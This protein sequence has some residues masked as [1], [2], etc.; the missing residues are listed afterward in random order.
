M[1]KK[2]SYFPVL[3]GVL[4]LLIFLSIVEYLVWLEYDR[5]I[6]T[7]KARNNTAVGLVRAKL[8]TEINRT[9]YLGLGLS[10]FVSATPRFSPAQFDRVAATLVSL[11]PNIHHVTLA[12]DNVVRYVYPHRGNEAIL[13]VEYLKDSS[14]RDAVHKAMNEKQPVLADVKFPQGGQWLV[15]HIPIF[16]LDKNGRYYYWGLASIAIDPIPL[17][18]AA[19]LNSSDFIFALRGNNAAGAIG[20]MLWGQQNIFNDQRAIVMEVSVPGGS[21]QLAGQPANELMDADVRRKMRHLIGIILAIGCGLSVWLIFKAHITIKS[22]AL[23]DPLTSLPN[24]RYLEA[25]ADSQMAFAKRNKSKF[26]ILHLDLDY[27]KEINDEYGHK[28]GDA[29]LLNV[30]NCARKALRESDFIAR[31]GGDEFIVLLPETGAGAGLQ[32]LIERLRAFIIQPVIHEGHQLKVNAS[33]GSAVYPDAGQK[34][35]QLIK[36]ADAKMYLEKKQ[37]KQN[38]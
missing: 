16:P 21:W 24:R 25:V 14:Q 26:T 28:A 8:E 2:I 27:F 38:A 33:I 15:N 18:S 31:I 17:Y 36:E 30:S 4:T 32:E 12:P 3:A 13:G 35:D 10:S 23:H 20:D 22:L 9:M 34:L 19:G 5:D 11:H 6:Q 29:V 1:T 37:H 7:M